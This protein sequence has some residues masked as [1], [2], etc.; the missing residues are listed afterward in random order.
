MPAHA[1]ALVLLSAALHLFWNSLVKAAKDPISFSHQLQGV[2]AL[3]ALP[4]GVAS[5]YGS[6]I[7]AWALVFATISGLCYAFYYCAL[8][9]S[10]RQG[11]IGIAYPIVRGVAPAGAALGGM[12]LYREAPSFLA[13]AGILIVCGATMGLAWFDVRRNPVRSAGP[14]SVAAAVI[15]G[16]FSAGYLLSD[17]AGVPIRTLCSTSACRSDSGSSSKAF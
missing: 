12:L 14:S 3:L 11:E 9:V 15:A 6:G 8:A 10:Y 13:G 16:L 17:K 5:V 1:V 4:F 2:G 7:G